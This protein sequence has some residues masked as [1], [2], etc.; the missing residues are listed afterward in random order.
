MIL[1]E[2]KLNKNKNYYSE[3]YK[4]KTKINSRT[5]IALPVTLTVQACEISENMP[6]L[7]Q[8][9]S[10]LHDMYLTELPAPKSIVSHSWSAYQVEL[11]NSKTSR[12]PCSYG[13]DHLPPSILAEG[14]TTEA[15]CMNYRLHQMA[16][17]S[18]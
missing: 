13:L 10:Y 7:D 12:K 14:E 3:Q 2:L 16:D 9:C 11:V 18:W 17:L 6:H 15:A 5:K 8:E 4:T 1:V